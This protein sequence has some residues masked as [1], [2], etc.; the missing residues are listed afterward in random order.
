MD[1]CVHVSLSTWESLTWDR[2]G[3]SISGP[4]ITTVLVYGMVSLYATLTQ[5][6]KIRFSDS[7][8]GNRLQFSSVNSLYVEVICCKFQQCPFSHAWVF[9][10]NPQINIGVCQSVRPP[11]MC[12]RSYLKGYTF[13]LVET[14]NINRPIR[15]INGFQNK[16]HLSG[17]IFAFS[18]F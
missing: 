13:K 8:G 7:T 14:W 9:N 16:F 15:L 12:W 17:T 1:W 3:S 6:L 4:N 2:A 10:K 18:F 11:E 5:G